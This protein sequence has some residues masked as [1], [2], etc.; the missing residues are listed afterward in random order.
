MSSSAST[1]TVKTAGP[2]VVVGPSGSGYLIVEET[3]EAALEHL[4]AEHDS[5]DESPGLL[6]LPAL[7]D[8]VVYDGQGQKLTVDEHDGSMTLVVAA[9]ANLDHLGE[10]C[11]RVEEAFAYVRARAYHDDSMLDDTELTHP[12]QIRPPDPPDRQRPVTQTATYRDYLDE[13]L[14]QL[15]TDLMEHKGSWWHNLFHR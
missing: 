2:I 1:D 9:A 7:S 6:G 11:A 12:G 13:L 14:T 3:P 5:S 15:R 8:L 4:G 10:L